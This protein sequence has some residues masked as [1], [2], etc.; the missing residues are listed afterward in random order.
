MKSARTPPW[1]GGCGLGVLPP[2][3]LQ[4]VESV[5]RVPVPLKPRR[6]GPAQGSLLS[7]HL[8]SEKQISNGGI[9]NHPPGL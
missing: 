6:H 4:Q 8:Q 5:T 7:L 2:G 3:V 9:S 1:A